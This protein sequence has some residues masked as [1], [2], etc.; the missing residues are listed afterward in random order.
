MFLFSCKGTQEANKLLDTKPPIVPSVHAVNSF[1]RSFYNDPVTKLW[2]QRNAENGS[3]GDH[4]DVNG[5]HSPFQRA[6]ENLRAHNYDKIIELCTEE[7]D[8]SEN[9]DARL[10]RGTFR[11][12]C[13]YRKETVNDLDAIIYSTASKEYKSAA[14][15]K[16]AAYMSLLGDNDLSFEEFFQKAEELWP[17]NVDLWHHR[18]QVSV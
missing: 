6:L 12:L 7:L 2:R 13:A 14:L 10:L 1:L 17:E 11:Y 4:A 3:S 18:G 9:F 5:S 16:K 15:V 8:K